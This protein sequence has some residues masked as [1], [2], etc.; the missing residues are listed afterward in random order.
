VAQ[1][2]H[3]PKTFKDPTELSLKD[4][5]TRPVSARAKLRAA[6]CSRTNVAR[7]YQGRQCN[8]R[9]GVG[10]RPPGKRGMTSTLGLKRRVKQNCNSE[11]EKARLSWPTG[12]VQRAYRRGG[13]AGSVRIVLSAIWKQFSPS[14]VE[15]GRLGTSDPE[16][17]RPV[18]LR[19]GKNQLAVDPQV[20]P[21]CSVP[22]HAAAHGGCS[23]LPQHVVI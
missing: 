1:G 14:L 7:D 9:G 10:C 12:T 22:R 5:K 13:I 23:A 20:L 3:W 8:V 16:T 2:L 21:K 15:T 19:C 11:R 18:E 17:L 4:M 6:P